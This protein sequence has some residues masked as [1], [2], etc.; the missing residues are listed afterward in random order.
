MPQDLRVNEAT[1]DQLFRHARSLHTFNDTPVSDQMLKELH[2]LWKLGPT[3]FNSQPA[4]IVFV[5]SQEAKQRLAPALAPTNLEKTVQAP[6][7]AIVAYDSKFFEH[8]P[9]QFPHAPHLKSMFESNAALASTAALRNG[10]LQGAYLIMAARALGL[11]A[12]PM[13]GFDNQK[14]DAEF[15][16]DGRFKSN[17]LINLGYWDGGVPRPRGPRLA[18]EDA[19]Q[20][21]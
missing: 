14:V 10:S 9:T 8:V 3:A 15:F 16:P 2:E 5:R 4:R 19:V 21:L 7:T 18:F 13:S 20:V 1:L 12:G 11:T 17:F 6:V